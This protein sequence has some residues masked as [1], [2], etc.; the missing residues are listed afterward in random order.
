M[1]ENQ[2]SADVIQPSKSNSTHPQDASDPH[3]SASSQ[4]QINSLES[5]V[6]DLQELVDIYREKDG[7]TVVDSKILLR[8]L[9][10]LE[11]EEEEAQRVINEIDSR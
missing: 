2:A 10:L 4:D 11:Q 3:E 7:D 1:G 8:K 6:T 5:Q 9:Q